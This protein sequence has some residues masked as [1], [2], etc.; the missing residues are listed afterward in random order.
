M[1][2]L[3]SNHG[4]GFQWRLCPRTAK[5]TEACFKQHPLPFVGRQS[6]QFPN[7]TRKQLLNRRGLRTTPM[8][9]MRY[10]QHM[11][12]REGCAHTHKKNA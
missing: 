1:W 10:S 4:G 2:G 5:L 11:L 7:G 9:H 3:R 8:N 6:L 12:T